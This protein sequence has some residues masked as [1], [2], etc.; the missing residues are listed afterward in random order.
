[1]RSHIISKNVFCKLSDWYT[2]TWKPEKSNENITVAEALDIAARALFIDDILPLFSFVTCN[3]LYEQIV[4]YFNIQISIPYEENLFEQGFKLTLSGQGV[5]F[6][7]EHLTQ[8]R[9]KTLRQALTRFYCLPKYGFK[10]KCTRFDVAFD[11]IIKK[12]SKDTPLLNLREISEYLDNGLFVSHLHTVTPEFKSTELVSDVVVDPYECDRRLECQ[13]ILSKKSSNSKMGFTINLG[14]R[15]SGTYIRFYDKIAEQEAKGIPVPEDVRH[16]IRFE[17]E[18][19]KEEAMKIFTAY[20]T[21]KSDED[22]VK[23]MCAVAMGKLRF[24]TSDRSR[25]YNCSTVVWWFE[26]LNSAQAA[27]LIYIKPNFNAYCRGVSAFKK[28][29]ASTFA[30]YVS[31]DFKNL[32]SI[33]RCGLAKTSKTAQRV[34]EA[35]KVYAEMSPEEQKQTMLESDNSLNG[36]ETLKQFLSMSEQEF[37]RWF[38]HLCAD[39]YE[40]NFV[41]NYA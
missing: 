41:G 3:K 5:N 10:I 31:C 7:L 8:K 11:E 20:V 18:F 14:N 40:E 1:M 19:K 15:K 33:V 29:R 38:N 25:K 34:Q 32:E 23:I 39:V 6:Y 26:F 4:D 27:R 21:A 36:I 12:D 17:L 22:F 13:R 30:A 9:K 37:D 28:Q 24:I 35:Y 16:W 2:F